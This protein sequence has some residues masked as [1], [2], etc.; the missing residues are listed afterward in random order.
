MKKILLAL[1][2]V[3]LMV[4]LV[5]PPS[6]LAITITTNDWSYIRNVGDTGTTLFRITETFTSAAELGG[7][8]NLYEYSVEN[9]STNLSASLFR[10]ANPDYLARTMSGPA[11]WNERGG[12]Q[13]FLWETFTASNY[14][15]PGETLAGFEIYTPGLIQLTSPPLEMNEIGWIM[16]FDNANNGARVDVF[17]PIAPVAPVPEPATMLLLG[18]GLVGLAGFRKKT[19][20]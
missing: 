12:A 19:K 8:D 16:A 9:L 5:V 11:G 1:G 13:N 20:K 2:A 3:C 6:A 15:N 18:T 7:S 14:I 4:F 17:G 10:V